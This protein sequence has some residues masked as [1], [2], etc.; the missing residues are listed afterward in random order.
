MSP[1]MML[2]RIYTDVATLEDLPDIGLV[3]LE[4]VE[5]LR[6]GAAMPKIRL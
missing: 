5:M 1:S 6:R 3:T 4:R 2:L